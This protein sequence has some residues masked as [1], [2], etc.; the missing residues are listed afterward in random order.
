MNSD[1]ACRSVE[2]PELGLEDYMIVKTEDFSCG[3][4]ISKTGR[5]YQGICCNGRHYIFET[6]NEHNF[7]VSTSGKVMP[8]YAWEIVHID[9]GGIAIV[10][11]IT[12]S[13]KLE[14]I[15]NEECKD[16]PLGELD[17]ASN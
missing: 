4:G 3:E 8:K 9:E 11:K 17:Y 10:K 6:P 16:F 14:R 2:I 13:A 1:E 15:I 7:D 12:D 5:C